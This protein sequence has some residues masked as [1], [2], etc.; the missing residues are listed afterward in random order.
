MNDQL[1]VKKEIIET[2]DPN[3]INPHSEASMNLRFI[4]PSHKFYNKLISNWFK[5]KYLLEE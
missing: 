4:K 2:N 3:E 5:F 1:I